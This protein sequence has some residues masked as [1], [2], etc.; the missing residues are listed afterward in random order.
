MTEVSSVVNRSDVVAEVMQ[1]RASGELGRTH[2]PGYLP[3]VTHPR[4]RAQVDAELHA[5][6]LSGE[7]ARYS[8]EA[9]DFAPTPSVTAFAY[10]M[11]LARQR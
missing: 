4:L 11:L 9:H 6:R 3:S 5:A 7:L 2:S 1:L 8:A 10:H